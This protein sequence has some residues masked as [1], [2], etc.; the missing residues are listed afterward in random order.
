M[1]LNVVRACARVA[2]RQE[3]RECCKSVVGACDVVGDTRA[4]AVWNLVKRVHRGARA[5]A[6]VYVPDVC[7]WGT[8]M[9]VHMSMHMCMCMCMSCAL[10]V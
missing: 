1:H 10:Y 2:A 3:A 8:H 9:H 4:G 7:V 5:S 6:Y